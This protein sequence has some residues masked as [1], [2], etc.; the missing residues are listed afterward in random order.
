[1]G[2]RRTANKVGIN[3]S[4][5]KICK[6]ETIMQMKHT[7]P[8]NI[9][10]SKLDNAKRREFL[11]LDK[12]QKSKPVDLTPEV[13]PILAHLNEVVQPRKRVSNDMD[14]NEK[15]WQLGGTYQKNCYNL[16][17]CTPAKSVRTSNNLWDKVILGMR[18]DK[19]SG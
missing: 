3:Q 9:R 6:H 14:L 1:M 7:I 13:C 8:I 11:G 10:E 16:S 19:K 12:P 2:M 17:E 5:S 18:N 4:E 15:L